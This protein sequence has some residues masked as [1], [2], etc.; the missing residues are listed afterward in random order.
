MPSAKTSVGLVR[1]ED[2]SPMMSAGSFGKSGK[3]TYYFMN[4]PTET[5]LKFTARYT[6]FGWRLT[7]VLADELWSNNFVLAFPHQELDARNVEDFNQELYWHNLDIGVYDEGKRASGFDLEQGEALLHIY[8]EGDGNFAFYGLEHDDPNYSLF[9]G[10]ADYSKPIIRVEAINGVDYRVPQ[11]KS[12]GDVMYYTINFYS[13]DNV[14]HGYRVHP[15]RAIRWRMNMVDYDQ[16]RGMS[17][18][19]P[20]FGELVIIQNIMNSAGRFAQRIGVGGI[21]WLQTQGVRNS[22]DRDAVKTAIGDPSQAEWF[23]TNKENI[24][25]IKMLGIENATADIKSLYDMMV[26]SISTAS[27]IPQGILVGKEPGVV[28]GGEVYERT[29]FATLDRYHNKINRFIYQ[30]YRVDPFAINLFKKYKIKQNYVID[31]GLR[32]VLT[33]SEEADLKMRQYQNVSTG[34]R[35][36][37]FKEARI[38]VGKPSFAELYK[39]I[40]GQCMDLFGLKPEELDLL[41]PDFGNFRQRLVQEQITSPAEQEATE[42]A[43][44]NTQ[45]AVE[46]KEKSQGLPNALNSTKKTT[47]TV[48]AYEKE[49]QRREAKS[50]RESASAGGGYDA[51]EL[52][53][54][55]LVEK[56][57]LFNDM[58][59][60]MKFMAEELK[61]GDREI[62]MNKFAELTGIKKDK[63]Y[64]MFKVVEEQIKIRESKKNGTLKDLPVPRSE[65]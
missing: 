1:G 63:L 65:I 12:F 44:N 41:V 42:L 10:K 13:A 40:E 34:L 39:G 46:S 51:L 58:I 52:A 60:Q 55:A 3:P 49:A 47:Q 56:E 54:A 45:N 30:L 21:P 57:L 32:Q 27:G 64:D 62:S 20:C 16:W 18:L 19:K 53:K 11:I 35:F 48:N 4:E 9:G 50:A 7:Y 37:T 61:K 6:P 22:R 25:D 36:L 33:K 26:D 43:A 15:T 14:F 5:E 2:N 23:I 29:Y 31:W 38:E 24:V 17:I 59:D 28:K 8:R